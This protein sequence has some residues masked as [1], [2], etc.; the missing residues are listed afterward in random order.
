M[1]KGRKDNEIWKRAGGEI[2]KLHNHKSREENW[3]NALNLLRNGGG[4]KEI[5][6]KS[7]IKEMIE[8]HPNNTT[9]KEIKK[10]FK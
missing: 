2:S 6:I 8:D 4:G 7:L 5:S 1:I 9:L 3:R 10:Y